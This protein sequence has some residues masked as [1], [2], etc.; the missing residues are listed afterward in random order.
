MKAARDWDLYTKRCWQLC[1]L[2]TAGLHIGEIRK[3]RLYSVVVVV[4]VVVDL[5]AYS[6]YKVYRYK[7][8]FF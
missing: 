1:Q 4:V 3:Y 6:T 7:Y 2:W 5:H 8:A